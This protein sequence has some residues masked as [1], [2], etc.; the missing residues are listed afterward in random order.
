MDP[1]YENILGED[2]EHRS[3]LDH[4]INGAIIELNH[5]MDAYILKFFGSQETAEKYGKLYVLESKDTDIV[6]G[7]DYKGTYNTTYR[8]RPKTVEELVRDEIEVT[9]PDQSA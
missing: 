6:F 5:S 7:P 1:N 2:D 4:V 8:I 9:T 3:A